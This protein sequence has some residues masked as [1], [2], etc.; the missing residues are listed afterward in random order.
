[1]E[2][3]HYIGFDVHKKSIQYCTKL[4]DGEIVKEGRI[5][6]T[7]T[8]LLAWAAQQS[9]PW[10]GA[11]EATMFSAWIYD[12]LQPHARELKVAHP[13]ML[14][15]IVAS[16]QASDRLDARNSLFQLENLSDRMDPLQPRPAVKVCVEAED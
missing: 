5:A 6:A 1:M 15:A 8:D 16:N 2:Y 12:T 10:K 11:L 4:A 3:L 13:A 9:H 7:R 14:K